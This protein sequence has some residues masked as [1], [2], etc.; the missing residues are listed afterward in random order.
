MDWSRVLGW[1]KKPKLWQ[2]PGSVIGVDIGFSSVKV[3]Q[4]K[5]E[6]GRLILET[7]GEIATGPY[8]DLAVGQAINLNTEQIV[9]LLDD[10]F[11]EA[12]VTSRTG[13]IAIPLR[14]S[15]LVTMEVPEVSNKEL[16]QVV[17]LEAR[18]YVPVPISEV[19]L[20][21]WVI[22]KKIDEE[23]T[24]PTRER[25]NTLKTKM[26]EVLVAA[27]HNDTLKQYQAIAQA[28]KL[29]TRFF[30]IETFGAIRSSLG[31]ELSA[32]A[33]LDLGAGTAKMTIVDY[34][35]VRV[36]HTINKG[37][38]DITTAVSRSL[39]VSFAK[40]EEIKRKVGLMEQ[41]GEEHIAPTVNPMIEFIFSEVNQVILDYQ[42]KYSRAVNKIILIGGGSLLAGLPEVAKGLVETPI[43]LG[44]P[45]D[46]VEAPP[47]L[48]DVLA[49][50][51]P[52]FAIALGVALRVLNNH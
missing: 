9:T 5:T 49:E 1:I 52:S 4:I 40:A 31:T 47:F 19:A 6:Q 10:L 42:R 7:Y 45:F 15:L 37:A 23:I 33:I 25:E 11:R 51:G 36:S 41:V 3:V 48:T 39:G 13:A 44:E 29:D 17:S 22:P 21:W 35:I 12:N 26:V 24:I 14:S 34:G 28:A 27:I 18:K 46:R 30:E 50:A 38:Q 16:P 43:V 2:T 8:G 20:D 32:T